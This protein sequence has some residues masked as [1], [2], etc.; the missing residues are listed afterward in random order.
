MKLT[1]CRAVR[2]NLSPITDALGQTSL[3]V[4]EENDGSCVVESAD[5]AIRFTYDDRDGQ[6]SSSIVFTSL[7]PHGA[8]LY[9]HIVSKITKTP[10]L[11]AS[12]DLPS[13]VR[14]E[15]ERVSD[16]LIKMKLA[17]ISARD[18]YYF[19]YGYNTAYT[20]YASGEWETR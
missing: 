10:R 14:D 18:L 1:L 19:Q 12:S 13:K 17:A 3:T 20:D 4:I 5:V 15:C 6:V 16:L 11:K 7:V 9:T 2:S 8:V